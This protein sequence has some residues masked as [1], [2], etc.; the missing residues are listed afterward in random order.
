MM[1]NLWIE[2]AI[3]LAWLAAIGLLAEWL[4]RQQIVS[5]ELSRKIVHIGAGNVIL[6]AWWLNFPAWMGVAA[7]ILFGAIAYVSYHVPLLPGINGV[8][9]K[10]L[11]TVFYAL[12]VGVLTALFWTPGQQHYTVMGILIMTWGDGMAALVGQR[13]GKHPYQIL[14]MKKSWEGSLT[15]L[16]ISF[17]ITSLLLLSVQGI[18]WQVWGIAGAVAIAATS[19]EVFSPFGIDNLTVPVGSALLCFALSQGLL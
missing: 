12:S 3:A 5:S 16:A 8:G 4:H 2:G 19:L 14:G 10:S 1:T 7:S 9:R 15:M 17:L 6:L 11:G 13:F 18:G